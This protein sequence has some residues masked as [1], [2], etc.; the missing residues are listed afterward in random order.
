MSVVGAAS[1]VAT[2]SGCPL[3][4]WSLSASIT[5]LVEPHHGAGL[6]AAIAYLAF[7]I[8]SIIAGLLVAPIGLLSTVLGHGV[9]I[10]VA[11]AA[12]LL[13]QTRAATR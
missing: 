6:F 13:A 7:G 1:A 11:A 2:I 8:P 3:R 12:G 9:V 4:N 5:P 10:I